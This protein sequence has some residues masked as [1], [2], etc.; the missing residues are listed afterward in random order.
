MRRPLVAVALVLLLPF[1]S[2]ARGEW[3]GTGP[4]VAHTLSC[5]AVFVAHIV[6]SATPGRWD[7]TFTAQADGDVSAVAVIPPQF[8]ADCV[9]PW[10]RTFAA[11][12]GAESGRWRTSSDDGCVQKFLSFSAIQFGNEAGRVD[13]EYLWNDRCAG[14]NDYD[15]ARGELVLGTTEPGVVEQTLEIVGD[16]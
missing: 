10:T 3:F 5:D 9:V 1:A 4:G 7:V 14:T 8:D 13:F 2:A 11:V 6:R 16:L 12:E 15:H